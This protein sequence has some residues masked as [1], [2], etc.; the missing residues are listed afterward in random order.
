MIG[1]EAWQRDTGLLELAG[2]SHLAPPTTAR[3]AALCEEHFSLRGDPCCVYARWKPGVSVTTAYSIGDS[4]KAET[5]VFKRYAGDK[6]D[7]LVDRESPGS[8]VLPAERAHLFKVP[9]DRGAG[10]CPRHASDETPRR[11]DGRV[12]SAPDAAGTLT[13]RDPALQAGAPLRASARSAAPAA[14]S[15]RRVAARPGAS[16]R[17]DP[18]AVDRGP[19]RDPSP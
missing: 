12:S 16:G 10:A 4:E 19:C 9:F 11:F 13:R 18:H 6:A 3:L 2:E 1:L 5:V 7:H 14:G 15:S 17:P 8:V